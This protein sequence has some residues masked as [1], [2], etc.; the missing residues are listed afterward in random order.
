MRIKSISCLA[1]SLLMVL[2]SACNNKESDV[3]PAATKVAR[4]KRIAIFKIV[5]H[6]AIDAMEKGFRDALAHDP[7]LANTQFQTY[8]ANGNEGSVAMYAD[9]IVAGNYDAAF[10]LGTPCAVQ[11][12]SRTKT[13]PIILGGATDPVGTGLVASVAKPG[14]NITGT[15]DLPPF[16]EHLRYLRALLPKVQTVG[17]IF[18]PGEDNSR[19]AVD[20]LERAAGAQQLK[21]KRIPIHAAVEISPAI[22]SN[23]SSIQALCLPTDNLIHSNMGPA[24]RAALTVHLPAFDCDVDS[25]KTGAL[26]SVAVE[27]Y[28]LGTL[29]ARMAHDIL[30]GG[31]KPA[32]MPIGELDNPQVYVN[33]RVASDLGLT[34]PSKWA[35]PVHVV[36]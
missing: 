31:K 27:Y 22:A 29:S 7:A 35:T 25:V 23:A 17:V 11:L 14:G 5:E 21:V 8:N 30:I 15:T 32:D 4:P 33:E 24:V 13:M 12:K 10:V 20:A 26:F 6:P 28:D 3:Q 18:N 1:A 34:P 9:T 16:G 2:L 19:L 36:K